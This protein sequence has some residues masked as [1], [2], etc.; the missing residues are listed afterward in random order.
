LFTSI[1]TLLTGMAGKYRK[2]F[3]VAH[4]VKLVQSFVKAVEQAPKFAGASYKGL[5]TPD[6]MALLLKNE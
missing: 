6:G 3:D 4:V 2:S 5:A 1:R